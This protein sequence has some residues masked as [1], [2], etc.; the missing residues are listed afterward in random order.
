MN[1]GSIGI[2]IAALV[3]GFY[4]AVDADSSNLR[5][6]RKIADN[7][8]RCAWSPSGD[9]RIA[10]DRKNPSDRYYDVWI[11]NADGSHQV[12]LTDPAPAGFPSRHVGNPS[13][14]PSGKYILVNAEK[15]VNP[16][17]GKKALEPYCEPGIGRNNDLWLI[18]SDGRQAWLLWENPTP[19]SILRAQP[20]LYNARFNHDG[21]KI[22]W[23]HCAGGG[24][25]TW[26]EYTI[27]V[28]E[29]SPVPVPHVLPNSMVEYSPAG[30]NFQEVHGWSTDGRRLD[31]SGNWRGQHEYDQDIG[32][33]DLTTGKVFNLTPA[34]DH[35]W[36]EAV[37]SHPRNGRVFY[38]SS[39]GYAI[40]CG[41][42]KWWEWLKTDYWMI[43]PDGTNRKRITWFNDVRHPE[44][45][46][47]VV[48][49]AQFSWNPQGDK[50]C[51]VL[52][53]TGRKSALE[54]WIFEFEE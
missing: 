20:A 32:I 47:D 50:F 17:V 38:M 12:C 19:K 42:K 44:Y 29:F 7:G 10:F 21:T 33:L 11:M 40:N 39:E 43:R 54:I 41:S 26:G 36:T 53:R 22:A 18:S 3:F 1:R 14:H 8:G 15:E 16:L 27:R 35:T 46:G 52:N 6:M 51:G 48:N 49:V 45:N 37:H 4:G 30:G 24:A 23:T 5:V 9:D 2:S 31:V 28:A 25:G 13:W 34:P